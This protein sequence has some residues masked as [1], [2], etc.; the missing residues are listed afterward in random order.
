MCS[1]TAAERCRGFPGCLWPPRWRRLCR[2][3][4]RGSPRTE[5][6]QSRTALIHHVGAGPRTRM[7]AHKSA[8]RTLLLDQSPTDFVAHGLRL[9][10]VGPVLG[11][12]LD[13]RLRVE[14]E[15]VLVRVQVHGLITQPPQ[16]VAKR[17]HGL[18]RLHTAQLHVLIIRPLVRSPRRGGRCHVDRA[19][20]TPAGGVPA[21]VR[22]ALVQAPRQRVHAIHVPFDY[23]HSAVLQV[24]GQLGLNA[25][26]VDRNGGG[27]NH[28]ACVVTIPQRVNRRRHQ[29]Q[30][31]TC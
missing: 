2:C 30:H 21:H 4:S 1:D 18:P 3:S 14:P 27:Q 12:P 11:Q 6:D 22:V 5:D 31:T 28:Q 16:R 10:V 19:R 26:V 23:R 25:R 24:S 7:H 29:P 20:N 17:G 8:G 15:A 9:E 13:G